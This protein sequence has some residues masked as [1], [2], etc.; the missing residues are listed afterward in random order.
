MRD[1]YI[2]AEVLLAYIGCRPAPVH[3]EIED[4]SCTPP[5]F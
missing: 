3:R 1:I 5:Y 2:T 4:A